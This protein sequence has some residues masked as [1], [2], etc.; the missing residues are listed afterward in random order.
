MG[1]EQWIPLSHPLFPNSFSDPFI[2]TSPETSAYNCVAWA[3]N[4]TGNWWEPD[5]G[6]LWANDIP[7]DYSITT[8]VLFLETLGFKVCGDASLEQSFE[9]IVLFSTDGNN[10]SHMARQLETGKW[11]S[12][13]GISHDVEH[14]LKSMAGGI[15]GEVVLIL[16]RAI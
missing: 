5:E 8:F 12:K 2:I 11:T 13:L 6:Y 9:K 4:D 15:Y 3:I 1:Q 14:S 10:C 16:K 7:F